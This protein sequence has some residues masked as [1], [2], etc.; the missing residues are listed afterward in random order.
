M[1]SNK[2][3]TEDILQ[4]LKN[5][6]QMLD[7]VGDYN[8]EYQ[9]GPVMLSNNERS[10]L[11]LSKLPLNLSAYYK[12]AIVYG[13]TVDFATCTII[14]SL[15]KNVYATITVCQ[16]SNNMYI[17]KLFENFL[18]INNEWEILKVLSQNH[19][20]HFPLVI[21]AGEILLEQ[22]KA[23][24]PAPMYYILHE[25]EETTLSNYLE[26]SK[27]F[28][29]V[30]EQLIDPHKNLIFRLIQIVLE[31][32]AL[33][34]AHNDFIPENI[35]ITKT[36]IK[37]SNFTYAIRCN[38]NNERVINARKI[39]NKY[40][41]PKLSELGIDYNPFTADKCALQRIIEELTKNERN[42]SKW[43]TVLPKIKSLSTIMHDLNTE[44]LSF[45]IM[46]EQELA[47]WL[48]ETTNV[49]T[50]CIDNCVLDAEK[51]VCFS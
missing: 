18:A 6:I 22:E 48:R 37:L 9:L 1:H 11:D 40:L 14:K 17:L 36:G 44:G 23:S 41:C 28:A 3:S 32:H 20:N 33:N 39:D 31:M 2:Q 30:T 19:P 38:S 4:I 42:A 7:K 49:A 8:L 13:G 35:I 10:V 24:I 43:K 51:I 46:K 45:D 34:I 26:K 21:S 27:F 12:D 50:N 16:D 15:S 47:S 25:E 5:E 29:D